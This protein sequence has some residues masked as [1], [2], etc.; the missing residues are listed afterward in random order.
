MPRP[1]RTRHGK[2]PIKALRQ[3]LMKPGVHGVRYKPFGVILTKKWL[4]EQCGRPVIYQADLEYASLPEEMRW[5]HVRYEPQIEPA[6]DFSGKREWK[7]EL[8]H[9]Q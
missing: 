7:Y 1:N 2:A 3:M 8:T 6:I 4:F 5:R 9:Y